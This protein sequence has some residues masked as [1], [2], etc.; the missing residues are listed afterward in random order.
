MDIQVVSGKITDFTC[1]AVLVSLLDWEFAQDKPITGAVGAVD[2]AL[3]GAIKALLLAGDLK[4]KLNKTAVLYPRGA[5]PAQRVI[6]V[7][8]GKAQELTADK[9]RQA[10]GTAAKK[11]RELSAKSL[12]IV[13]MGSGGGGLDAKL[14]AQ[15]TVEG[16]LLALY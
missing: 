8:L 13:A 1:D 15:A 4:G 10:A 5:I 9:V 3:G 11:A 6:V 16:M 14:A 7:G 12:A 2:E